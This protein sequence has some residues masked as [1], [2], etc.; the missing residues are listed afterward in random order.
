MKNLLYILFL[1]PLV[2]IAQV[3]SLQQLI[4][5]AKHDTIIVNAWIAWDNIIWKADPDK[6]K[7]LKPSITIPKACLPH[8]RYCSR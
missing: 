6:A 8:D 2:S 5:T 4:K 1:L 3:D 7:L